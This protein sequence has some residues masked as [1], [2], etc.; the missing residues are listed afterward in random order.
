MPEVEGV[1]FGS[2]SSIRFSI[3]EEI[4]L[5]VSKVSLMLWMEG[6]ELRRCVGR[7]ADAENGLLFSEAE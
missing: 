2:D 6:G 1:F 5:L 7:R 3:G 4:S